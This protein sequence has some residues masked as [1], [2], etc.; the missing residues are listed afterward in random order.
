MFLIFPK[1][2]YFAGLSKGL[3]E[4][5]KLRVR[6][7]TLS[8]RS[9]SMPPTSTSISIGIIAP[10]V[11][12]LSLFFLYQL[13]RKGTSATIERLKSKIA[14]ID[15]NFKNLAVRE[16]DRSETEDKSLITLCIK[17][18]LTKKEYQ[19]NTL[20]YVM[21]HEVAHT[22]NKPEYSEHGSEWQA[23][24]TGLLEQAEAKGI[25]NS[26]IPL[27]QWYCGINTTGS[28]GAGGMVHHS[29]QGVST[30]PN[31]GQVK[32]GRRKKSKVRKSVLSWA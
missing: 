6:S 4:P 31:P 23:I 19:D 13:T 25:Y 24:F 30:R 16:G 28:L 1:G 9:S 22:L 18:P 27:D 5:A 8:L 2:G 21:L 14:K 20:I 26:A 15:P 29:R 3:G 17:D 12:A 7:K 10:A 32:I 11:I